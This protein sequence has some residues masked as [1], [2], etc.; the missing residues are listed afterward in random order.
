MCLVRCKVSSWLLGWLNTCDYVCNTRVTWSACLLWWCHKLLHFETEFCFHV[1]ITRLLCSST[2]L[3]P[4]PTLLYNQCLLMTMFWPNCCYEYNITTTTT[5]CL[6][7]QVFACILVKLWKRIENSIEN[8]KPNVWYDLTIVSIV[9]G[10][11]SSDVRVGIVR[12][13]PLFC[14][15]VSSFIWLK[16]MTWQLNSCPLRASLVII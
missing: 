14:L 16:F 3:P 5:P 2:V 6:R 12:S 10:I 8:F 4:L 1:Y 7:Q 15:Q 9:L 13:Q 11:C